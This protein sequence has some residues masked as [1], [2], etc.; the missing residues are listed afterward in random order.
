MGGI[1]RLLAY[2]AVAVIVVGIGWSLLLFFAGRA[3]GPAFERLQAAVV[4]VLVV[5]AASGLVLLAVGARPAKGLHV[6]YAIVAIALI[7]LARS[8]LGGQTRAPRARSSSQQ[9]SSSAGW[10]TGSSRL[11]EVL[12]APPRSLAPIRI[13]HPSGRQRASGSARDRTTGPAEPAPLFVPGRGDD[14]GGREGCGRSWGER[15]AGP[16]EVSSRRHVASGVRTAAS[17]NRNLRVMDLLR[18]LQLAC[19]GCRLSCPNLRPS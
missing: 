15:S 12:I 18:L 4:S 9:S 2:G 3:G 17:A 1:H 13:E 19:R 10:H 11:V 6:L 14:R 7:P 5:G 8:L 16:S